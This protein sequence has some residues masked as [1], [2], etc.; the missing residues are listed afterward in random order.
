MHFESEKYKKIYVEKR[1]YEGGRLALQLMTPVGTLAAILTVNI[2]EEDKR[3]KPGE[4][5]VKAWSEN[6]TI[7]KEALASGLFED[8]GRRV[9]TGWVEAQIWRFAEAV[10]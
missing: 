4:F 6:E 8:T 2:P 10:T 7:A 9:K 1:Q 3:L 5:F